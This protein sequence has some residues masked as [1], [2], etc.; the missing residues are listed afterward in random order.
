MSI[1]LWRLVV[2]PG[3]DCDCGARVPEGYLLGK[4]SEDPRPRP[5]LCLH[6]IAARVREAGARQILN[7]AP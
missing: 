7:G 6:C 4:Y 1:P 2:S 5:W 3:A